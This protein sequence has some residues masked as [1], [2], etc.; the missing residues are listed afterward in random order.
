LLSISP[1]CLLPQETWATVGMVAWLQPQGAA[2][3]SNVRL[4]IQL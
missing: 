1:V 3:A 4:R 2:E